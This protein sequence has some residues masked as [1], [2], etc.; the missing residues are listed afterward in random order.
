MLHQ[1]LT[2]V[3]L[4]ALNK[5]EHPVRHVAGCDVGSDSLRHN[6]T[7]AG[8]GGVALDN[9]GAACGECTGGV[10]TRNRKRQREV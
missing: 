5:A 9:H 3:T 7:G 2:H 8:M 10:A 4:A 6:L 1:R